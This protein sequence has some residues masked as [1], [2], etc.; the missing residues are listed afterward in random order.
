VVV[1]AGQRGHVLFT[2][3]LTLT[4]TLQSLASAQRR[5]RSEIQKLEAKIEEEKVVWE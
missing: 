4:L 3:T 2:L 1:D 5:S